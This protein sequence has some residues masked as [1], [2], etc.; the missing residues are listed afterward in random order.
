MDI[1]PNYNI[2][3]CMTYCAIVGNYV[4]MMHVT[5][6]M[7]QT[8]ID[9]NSTNLR[10][11]DPFAMKTVGNETFPHI[12]WC[13]LIPRQD[14]PNKVYIFLKLGAICIYFEQ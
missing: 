8:E 7:D 5:D 11:H 6:G 2:Y 13:N 10:I 14:R 12:W 1:V 9:R 3:L 4:L